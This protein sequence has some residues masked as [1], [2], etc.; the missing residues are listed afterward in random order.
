MSCYMT[1]QRIINP[2][3]QFCIEKREKQSPLQNT[4]LHSSW[5]WPLR[6]DIGQVRSSSFSSII[7][8]SMY[9]PGRFSYCYTSAPARVQ[10]DIRD[11]TI[12]VSSVKGFILKKKKK[13]KITCW[14]VILEKPNFDVQNV[15]A[16]SAAGITKCFT[17][18]LPN[19]CSMQ[20]YKQWK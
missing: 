2:Q 4:L 10:S 3:F 13:K 14:V 8:F 20:L 5:F 19:R 16:S 12:L 7:L 18:R 17:S 6:Y 9:I 1:Q 15:S 11:I